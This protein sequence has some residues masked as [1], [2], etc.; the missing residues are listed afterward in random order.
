M[1]TFILRPDGCFWGCFAPMGPRTKLYLNNV[2]SSN[3]QDLFVILRDFS[4]LTQVLIPQEEV[5]MKTIQIPQSVITITTNSKD[6]NN[7][8]K[9]AQ[10]SGIY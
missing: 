10:R 1:I 4:G 5:R 2:Y 7:N 6:I 8:V 9:L 3:R